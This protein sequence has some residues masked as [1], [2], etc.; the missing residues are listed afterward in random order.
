[1][2]DADVRFNRRLSLLV[3]VSFLFFATM[4]A[5]RLGLGSTPYE[6]ADSMGRTMG[7][8]DPLDREHYLIML[9]N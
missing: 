8:N 5:L 7:F 2:N 9:K 6:T 1:M 3:M 4:L